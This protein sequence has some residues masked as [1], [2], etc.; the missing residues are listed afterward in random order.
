MPEL[1]RADLLARLPPEPDVTGLTAELRDAAS[2]RKLVVLDDDPTGT[3]TVHGVDVLTTWTEAD[4]T[5]AVLGSEPL[6]YVLTN[7]RALTET[8]AADLAKTLS[9]T[10]ARVQEVTGRPLDILSR[11]DSTLR[12]HYPA[13]LSPL[14][15]FARP[16]GH[17]I[18]PAF[19]EGGRVTVDGVHYVLAGDT[20][21][22]VTDTDF[23][24]D[25]TFGYRHAYLPAW[26]EEKTG[27]AWRQEEVLHVSIQTVRVGGPDA[28]AAVLMQAEHN[29]PVVADAVT[30]AD[31]SVLAAGLAR[32]ERAG[33]RFLAR[34]AASFVRVRGGLA[35]KPLLTRTDLRLNAGRGGMVL[36]GSYVDLSA[37]QLTAARE[38]EGVDARELSV[39]TLL[40]HGDPEAE[41]AALARWADSVM[42]TGRTALIYTSRSLVTEQGGKTHVEIAALVSAA[43]SSV[44]RHLPQ[45]PAWIVDKGGIN[46]SDVDTRGLGVRKARVLGQ[47]KPGIPTWRLG[48]ESRFPGMPYLVF[49]G[50][51]GTDETL[52]DIITLLGGEG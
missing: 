51:V 44:P 34:T 3:Q 42:A 18:V 25:P 14:T 23:A 5:A 11:S 40:E 9:E 48:A 13:E 50:N 52:A 32:A 21:R 19:P 31:L 49:P 24:R 6:F 45:I 2:R 47:V 26:V 43:L 46:S 1:T 30:Y 37:R 7:S 41:A 15:D 38:L 16:N 29:R 35:E 36:V 33:K 17:L 22:P 8:A 27:G 10:L 12:G 39:Q 28:V 4:L 20:Y